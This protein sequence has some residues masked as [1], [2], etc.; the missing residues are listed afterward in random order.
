MI[1]KSS[2]LNHL[3]PNPKIS[4]TDNIIETLWGFKISPQIHANQIM[5]D[6][7]QNKSKG[8]DTTTKHNVQ[9][10]SGPLLRKIK[11]LERLLLGQLEKF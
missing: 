4:K 9:S 6:K 10:V 2:N 7:Q 5:S 8:R 3:E 11:Q 1:L